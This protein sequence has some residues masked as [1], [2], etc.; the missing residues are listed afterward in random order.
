MNIIVRIIHEKE[1][2]IK[3]GAKNYWPP[4]QNMLISPPIE[5]FTVPAVQL[6]LIKNLQV[7]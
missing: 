4:Q 5:D 2:Q 3:I 6:I 1:V 7:F